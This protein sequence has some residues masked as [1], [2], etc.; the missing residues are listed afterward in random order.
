MY[1]YIRYD[2]IFYHILSACS[3]FIVFPDYRGSRLRIH[4]VKMLDQPTNP[5]YF[6]GVEPTVHQQTQ[7]LFWVVIS[8]IKQRDSSVF[9]PPTPHPFFV[10][11]ELMHFSLQSRY[12]H[13]ARHGDETQLM[14][15][16]HAST[17]QSQWA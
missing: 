3:F 7:T 15:I 5:Q 8:A 6:R 9:H 16:I 12:A 14:N 2:N 17:R 10:E 11:I 1:T 13:R 4:F